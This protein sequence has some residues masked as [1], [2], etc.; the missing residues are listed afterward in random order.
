MRQ[1]ND[2]SQCTYVRTY[3]TYMY[4]YVCK[5]MHILYVCQFY[6]LFTST[7]IRM[8]IRTYVCT[9]VHTYICNMLVI[10]YP[11]LSMCVSSTYV[12][13]YVCMYILLHC[14]YEPLTHVPPLFLP[15]PPPLQSQK[16]GKDHPPPGS[17]S[18]HRLPSDQTTLFATSLQWVEAIALVALCSY[19]P[20]TRRVALMILKEVRQLREVIGHSVAGEDANVMDV[21]DKA[22]PVIIARHIDT[23]MPSEKVGAVTLCGEGGRVLD[24]S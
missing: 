21:I 5:C 17:P 8:Y 4:T 24:D 19:R 14:H 20:V 10:M 12:R 18:H 13:T 22:A 3:S 15:M 7:Y 23:L 1:N 16:K 9:I 11:V 2:V 6:C